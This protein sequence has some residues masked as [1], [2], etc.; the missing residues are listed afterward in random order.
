VTR[1]QAGLADARIW[2]LFFLIGFGL[3]YPALNRYDIRKAVPDVAIYA[4]LATYGPSAIQ[5]PLRF[6]VLVPLL[7]RIIFRLAQVTPEAGTRR[8][9]FS[10]LTPHSLQPPRTF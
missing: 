4:Q 5:S 10:L 6:R 2:V 8:S 9:H 3:G 7:S 1:I